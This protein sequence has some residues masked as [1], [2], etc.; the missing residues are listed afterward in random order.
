VGSLAEAQDLFDCEI[1]FGRVRDKQWRIE[2]SNLPFREGHR[3]RPDIEPGTGS[4][5]VDDIAADG[6]S[7][8]RAW[9]IV[10]Y[11][12]TSAKPLRQ[13]LMSAEVGNKNLADDDP[14]P[15]PKFGAAR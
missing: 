4:L 8:R 1:S 13:W 15:L 3:L 10:S 14:N 11:A 2:R 12:G 7:I 5:V 6:S 9:Q